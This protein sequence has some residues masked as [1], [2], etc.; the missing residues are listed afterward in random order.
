MIR[1][2]FSVGL[3]GLQFES[4]KLRKSWDFS[5][6]LCFF[7]WMFFFIFLSIFRSGLFIFS[8]HISYIFKAKKIPNTFVQVCLPSQS[9]DA[10][11]RSTDTQARLVACI[12]PLKPTLQLKPP[13]PAKRPKRRSP[14]RR[15]MPMRARARRFRS[16]WKAKGWTKFMGLK[17]VFF[18]F[19]SYGE[20]S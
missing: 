10:L 19:T 11:I 12:R 14:K 20:I 17:D 9:F 8:R 5:F 1:V 4:P 18:R 16:F 3:R 2:L 7:V 6:F 15:R 13:L